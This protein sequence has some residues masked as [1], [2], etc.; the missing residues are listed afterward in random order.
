M[1][2]VSRGIA[3]PCFRED[4]AELIELGVE[5]ERAGF[6]GFFPWDHPGVVPS[7]PRPRCGPYAILLAILVLSLVAGWLIYGEHGGRSGDRSGAR[8]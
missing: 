1:A 8:A 2:V 4:P 7:R 6:D 3:V 5:A